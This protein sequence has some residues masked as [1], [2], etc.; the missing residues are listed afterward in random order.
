MTAYQQLP[1]GPPQRK[2]TITQKWW[3]WVALAVV[4]AAL[5][6]AGCSIVI[7]AANMTTTTT[8]QAAQTETTQPRP[9]TTVH[10]PVPV[11][12]N[13]FGPGI[14]EVGNEIQPGTYTTPGGSYCYWARLRDFNGT[15]DSVITN[16]ILDGRGRMTI[17]RTDKG[18]EFSGDCEWRKVN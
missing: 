9:P 16:N 17:K 5:L 13:A 15:P 11:P 3:F 7:G 2:K 14:Y 8:E 12:V 1:Q 18:I 10:K 6:F 4:V